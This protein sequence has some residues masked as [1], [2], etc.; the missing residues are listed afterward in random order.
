ME[1][2]KERLD[3]CDRVKKA[4]IKTI[5]FFGKD[6]LDKSFIIGLLSGITVS[7]IPI[8]ANII[9][10]LNED[11]KAIDMYD[12]L[13]LLIFVLF[14]L[15]GLLF[16][17]SYR[18]K[19]PV[20]NKEKLDEI[21]KMINQLNLKIDQLNSSQSVDTQAKSDGVPTEKAVEGEANTDEKL[22]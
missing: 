5:D 15:I 19:N 13:S 6:D 20:S 12:S 10:D 21:T 4:I 11:I 14:L 18:K 9:R 17:K 3:F 2:E 22:I 7:T 16:I 1:E 8:M